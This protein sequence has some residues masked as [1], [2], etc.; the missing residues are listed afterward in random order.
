MQTSQ[1]KRE[2]KKPL[3]LLVDCIAD[4]DEKVEQEKGTV[5]L[6]LCQ[7]AEQEAQME[8]MALEEGPAAEA[9]MQEMKTTI[10]GYEEML[11]F[12]TNRQERVAEERQNL[13]SQLEDRQAAPSPAPC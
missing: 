2:K 6:L 9:A 5:S 4:L 10:I 11:R 1:D 8:M 12:A 3:D 7:I 13:L